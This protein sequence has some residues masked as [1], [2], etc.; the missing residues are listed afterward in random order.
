MGF[1]AYE[2]SEK[3]E[4]DKP[5]RNLINMNGIT[6]QQSKRTPHPRIKNPILRTQRNPKIL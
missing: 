5:I 1:T 2:N 6:D 4:T 3:L